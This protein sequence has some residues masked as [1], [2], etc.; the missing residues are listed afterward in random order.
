MVQEGL[1][2]LYNHGQF[3][4]YK[5]KGSFKK[6][7]KKRTEVT[8]LINRILQVSYL[9]LLLSHSPNLSHTEYINMRESR[10]S[11]MSCKIVPLNKNL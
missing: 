10:L 7:K 9:S 5:N 2:E 11:P 8:F 6:R 1:L 3:A 4:G